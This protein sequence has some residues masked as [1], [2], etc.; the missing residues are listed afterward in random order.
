MSAELYIPPIR[1]PREPQSLV[2]P[3]CESPR[4]TPSNN[5]NQLRGRRRVRALPP[6]PDVELPAE[7][8]YPLRVRLLHLYVN[9]CF[10]KG[11]ARPAGSC[12]PGFAFLAETLGTSTL[13]VRRCRAELIRLGRI[14]VEPGN[15]RRNDT[16]RLLPSVVGTVKQRRAAV[17]AAIWA[18]PDLSLA[19][20]LQW[21]IADHV[22]DGKPV[23]RTLAQLA[24]VT[25]TAGDT[26]RKSIDRALHLNK[27]YGRLSWIVLADRSGLSFTVQQQALAPATARQAP[28]TT[29]K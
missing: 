24:E 18:C 1:R 7:A 29:A 17:T 12:G 21:L 8:H 4:D 14:A 16:V 10:S 28:T 25:G 20:R 22:F 15:G 2:T 27:S 9:M 19:Y 26:A 6:T 11:A 3:R 5:N 23:V 13:M